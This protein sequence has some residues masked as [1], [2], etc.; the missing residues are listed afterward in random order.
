MSSLAQNILLRDT[1]GQNSSATPSQNAAPDHADH[2]PV[3]KTPK[4]PSRWKVVL[5]VLIVL[6]AVVLG[7]V[8]WVLNSNDRAET[9][10]V[11]QGNIDIRQVNMAFKVGGRIET[12][13]FDE[14][15]RVKAG[16]VL[17][18]L[19]QRYFEDD[20]RLARAQRDAAAATFRRYQNGSRPE[21]VDQ[22]RANVESARADVANAR[23]QYQRL[24]KLSAVRLPDQTVAQA[25]SQEDV[26]N[27][28]TALDVAEAKLVV[29]QKSLALA[30]IGPREEDVSNA[31]ASF[32]A[33]EARVV[34]SERNLSDSKMVAPNDGTILTRAREK[35]AIVQPGEVV[36]TLTLSSPVW[37]RAYVG[38]TDLGAVRPGMAARVTTDSAPGKVYVGHIGFISPTAEFTP[39]AVETRELRTDL[40]YRLRVVVDNPDDGLRQGMP[41]TATLDRDVPRHKSFWR[42][43]RDHLFGSGSRI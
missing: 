30:L 37:V 23:S 32:Q 9:Q 3:P 39:K 12:L 14:G 8:A 16:Q 36:F 19:E 21:E 41:V 20:L 27:A 22:A 42:R 43:V 38:E 24:K 18:T 17:A 35:G 2:P 33:E 34:V 6:A 13:D 5:L 25:V 28:K 1:G 26:D 11:L 31:K 29:N 4:A 7:F 15:D 10:I 40:V